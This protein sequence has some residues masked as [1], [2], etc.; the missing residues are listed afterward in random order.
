[1]KKYIIWLFIALP[2]IIQLFRSSPSNIS[3]DNTYHASNKYPIS[4]ELSIVLKDACYDCHSNLTVYPKYFN[5]QPMGWFLAS[6][7]KN[8]RR[9]LNFSEFTKKRIAVQNH[10]LEEIIEMTE[11]EKMPIAS[12]TYFGLHPEAKLSKTQRKLIIDWAKAA[13]DTIQHNYP[14]DSLKL[15]R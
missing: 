6:H 15:K 2:F 13:R 7:V 11:E 9:E 4:N 10:K 8:G 12:Y 3:N 14:A 1:M 5:Y